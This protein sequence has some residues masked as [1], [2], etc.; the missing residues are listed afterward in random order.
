MSRKARDEPRALLLETNPSSTTCVEASLDWRR[1]YRLTLAVPSDF[2]VKVLD[3]DRPGDGLDQASVSDIHGS[4]K[5][6]MMNERNITGA[7]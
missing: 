5:R 3:E 7:L 2:N 4:D 6:T 1:L